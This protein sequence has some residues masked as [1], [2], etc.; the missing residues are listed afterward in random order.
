MMHFFLSDFS[1][2][3]TPTTQMCYFLY[4]ISGTG[5]NKSSSFAHG[6]G[7]CA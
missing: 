3:T 5:A 7:H 1:L 6:S 4:A 2:Q